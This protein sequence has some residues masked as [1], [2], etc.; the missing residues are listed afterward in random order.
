MHLLLGADF[1]ERQADGAVLVLSEID[2]VCLRPRNDLRGLGLGN[3]ESNRIE[4]DLGQHLESKATQAFREQQ[5]QAMDPFRDATQP[6]RPMVDR[7]HGCHHRQ[8]DLSGADVTRGLFPSDVL[9][10]CLQ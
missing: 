2:S 9:L 1:V 4:K 3:W 10:A 8:Q 7:E 6:I 5:R